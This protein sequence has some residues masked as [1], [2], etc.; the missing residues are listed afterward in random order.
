MTHIVGF[1]DVPVLTKAIRSPACQMR[2]AFEIVINTHKYIYY[3][4]VC[5]CVSLHVVYKLYVYICIQMSVIYV[6]SVLMPMVLWVK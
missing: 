4:S 3:I 5:V 6:P 2:I 1:L